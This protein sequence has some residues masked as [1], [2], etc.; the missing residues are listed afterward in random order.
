MCS[1]AHA[2]PLIVSSPFASCAILRFWATTAPAMSP[3]VVNALFSEAAFTPSTSDPIA[4]A[5]AGES[6][7]ADSISEAAAGWASRAPRTSLRWR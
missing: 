1:A 2:F 5:A 6:P 7:I 3:A 4:S